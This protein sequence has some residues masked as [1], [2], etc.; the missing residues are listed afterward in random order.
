MK[1]NSKEIQKIVDE[2]HKECGKDSIRK[3]IVSGKIEKWPVIPTRSISLDHALGIGGYPKGRIVEIFGPESSGKTTMAL[4]AVAEAQKAGGITA[5][6]DVEHAIDPKYCED[7]GVNLDDLL[8]SQP[9]SAEQ[10]LQITEKLIKSNKLDVIVM[11][12]VAALVP[13]AELDGEMGEQHVGLQARLMGQALRK[14]KGE[15][16]KTK[17]CMIF[18]NQI[19]E[20]I[21]MMMPGASNEVTPGGRA[22]KFYASVRID[23]R[24]I[25]S[26]SDKDNTKVGNEIRCK[27][28]KNKL[29]PPFKEAKFQITFG[30]GIDRI[31]NI[32]DNAVEMNIVNRSGS[33]Y[34]YGNNKLGASRSQ[35][36]DTLTS[37]NEFLNEIESKVREKLFSDPIL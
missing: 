15:L 18:I 10:A 16:S 27:V 24:R 6:I 17:T 20:K 29:A 2:V 28:T 35:A 36:I 7:L 4:T 37:K 1:E 22:L 30:K 21:G 12:S 13:K 31:G 19:R 26:V 11:D 32:L 5:Y 14:L 34:S 23:I 33:T 9:D 25:G 3:G 8:F